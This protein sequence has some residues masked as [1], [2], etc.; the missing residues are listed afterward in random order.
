M[1]QLKERSRSPAA[2]NTSGPEQR[3]R[4]MLL[5]EGGKKVQ[6]EAGVAVTNKKIFIENSLRAWENTQRPGG[7]AA[8]PTTTAF[9]DLSSFSTAP[10]CHFPRASLDALPLPMRLLPSPAAL[11]LPDAKCLRPSTL[12]RPKERPVRTSLLFL[13]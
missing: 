6:H 11:P 1:R 5:P 12:R 8:H 3:P 10:P 7:E 13:P 2:N 9:R 4:T